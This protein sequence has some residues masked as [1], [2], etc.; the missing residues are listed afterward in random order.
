MD[1]SAPQPVKVRSLVR[2]RCVLCMLASAADGAEPT[3]VASTPGVA[4]VKQYN[5]ELLTF[6]NADRVRRGRAP[7]SGAAIE[8]NIASAMT[9]EELEA[10]RDLLDGLGASQPDEDGYRS[11]KMSNDSRVRIGGFAEDTEVAGSAV[12]RLPME[13]AV[14]SEFSTIEAALVLRVATAGNLFV[15]GAGDSETVAT[16]VTVSDK[17]FHK[18]FRNAS[19][20]VDEQALAQWI[21]HNITPHS[22]SSEDGPAPNAADDR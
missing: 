2:L 16:P 10:V 8:F 14:A 1:M 9:D 19:V 21:R 13:F 18:R 12:E 5:F 3:A 22:I 6:N 7:F 4:T 17:R 15:V 11:L 20:T